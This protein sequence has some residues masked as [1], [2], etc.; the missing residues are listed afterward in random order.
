MTPSLRQINPIIRKGRQLNKSAPLPECLVAAVRKQ[1]PSPD[2][3]YKG[4]EDDRYVGSD[5]E[6]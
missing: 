4:Y 6:E 3:T 1:Y 2:G 5:P